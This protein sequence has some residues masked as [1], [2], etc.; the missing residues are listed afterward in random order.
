[1]PEYDASPLPQG[2]APLSQIVPPLKFFFQVRVPLPAMTASSISTASLPSTAHEY[3]HMPPSVA[4]SHDA[5][6][7]VVPASI[8]PPPAVQPSV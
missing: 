4:P 5:A 8:A 6:C 1:M 3:D 2:P 7:S